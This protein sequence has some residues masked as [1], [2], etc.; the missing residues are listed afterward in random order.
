M[1]AAGG[2]SLGNKRVKNIKSGGK[3]KVECG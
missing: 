3:I 2:E 1:V